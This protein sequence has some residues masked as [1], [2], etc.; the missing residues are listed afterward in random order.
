M[1]R[2]TKF[3]WRL[4]ALY[5]KWELYLFRLFKL[6]DYVENSL[7]FT[8]ISGPEPEEYLNPN[9]FESDVLRIPPSPFIDRD[10]D[11]FYMFFDH[12]LDLNF[13]DNEKGSRALFLEIWDRIKIIKEFLGITIGTQYVGEQSEEKRLCNEIYWYMKYPDQASTLHRLVLG[14]SKKYKQDLIAFN[15]FLKDRRSI[16]DVKSVKV[17]YPYRK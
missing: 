4:A 6:A 14:D 7:R 3:D 16:K 2:L 10:E 11:V 12:L 8:R 1:S 9:G 5:K 13:P 17:Y 15:R